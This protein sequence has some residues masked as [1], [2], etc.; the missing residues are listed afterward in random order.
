M[1]RRKEREKRKGGKGKRVKEGREGGGFNRG[2][3]SFIKQL[4]LR[5]PK[6]SGLMQG[7]ALFYGGPSTPWSPAALPW[8]TWGSFVA[9][10]LD[11]L[12]SPF[13]DFLHIHSPFSTGNFIP[14]APVALCTRKT[15]GDNA[16]GDH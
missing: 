7:T 15:P 2:T 5:R 11:L 10:S 13:P 12:F 3:N 9:G 6:S 1:E 14:R 4:G 16:Q 8:V